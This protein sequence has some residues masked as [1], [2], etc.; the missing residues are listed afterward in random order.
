MILF[1]A[2]DHIPHVGG[3][4]THILDLMSG[5]EYLGEETSL[6]SQAQFSSIKKTCIKLII[7]VTKL[8]NPRLFQYLYGK[9]WSRILA[10]NILRMVKKCEPSCIS[11]QDAFAAASL[12]RIRKKIHC[13]IVLTMHTYFGLENGLDCA[14]NTLQKHIYQ[15]NLDFELSA[16]E[17]VDKI[18]AVDNRIFEHVKS[19]ID[20]ETSNRQICVKQTGAIENFTNTEVFTPGERE[21][22]KQLRAKYGIDESA[23]V[24]AC[25]RRLV[26]K[27]GVIYAVDAISRVNGNCIL[28]IAGDGPQSDVITKKIQD[29][30]LQGKV[31]QLGS[32]SP[33][34][35]VEIYKAS[36]CSVVPSITVNG[37]QEATSI[38]ALEAMAC[39]LPTIA[40]RIG[41]LIQLIINDENGYLVEEKQS[42]EIAQAIEKLQ[43]EQVRE[44]L[45][46]SA[47]DYVVGHHSYIQGAR[48]Y[49][50]FFR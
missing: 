4:S 15:K 9:V 43:N 48:E 23:F 47:R 17:V 30:N 50:Q 24:V 39:G 14:K 19:T 3:K 11:C 5:L 29:E 34:K 41:G 12:K 16:L 6:Y 20:R 40:S 28:V 1:V 26:E 13:P 25:A 7:G 38:S 32:I 42:G 35:I 33:N 10:K 49:M 37:L 2:S 36:D 31:K 21:E 22:K 27:N 45:S 18:V 46:V 44:R 8:I